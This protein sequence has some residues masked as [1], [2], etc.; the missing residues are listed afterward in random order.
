MTA[1]LVAQWVGNIILLAA[2]GAAFWYAW[3]A[4]VLRLQMIRP[5]VIFFFEPATER[6]GAR[7]VGEGVALN[8]GLDRFS[9]DSGFFQPIP[10]QIPYLAEGETAYLTLSPVSGDYRPNIAT[11]LTATI[12][13][14]LT[15]RYSDVEGRTFA[16]RTYV[17]GAARI[18]FIEDQ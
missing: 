9:Q 8:I 2:G 13:L 6:F 3:E 5:K 12:S 4:R 15:S 16:T 14:P 1:V 10:S 11:I 18:P 7:N 17:G